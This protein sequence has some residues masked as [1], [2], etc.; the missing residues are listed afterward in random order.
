MGSEGSCGGVRGGSG[1]VLGN[2]GRVLGTNVVDVGQGK[3]GQSCVC[4]GGGGLEGVYIVGKRAKAPRTRGYC[5]GFMTSCEKKCCRVREL[6]V[7]REL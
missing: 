2:W 5:N 1:E 4:H 6:T 7:V 3:G